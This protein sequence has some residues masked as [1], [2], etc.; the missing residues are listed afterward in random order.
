MRMLEFKHS[1]QQWEARFRD[2]YAS[3]NS[4]KHLVEYFHL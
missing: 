4:L 3:E 2:A 1:V